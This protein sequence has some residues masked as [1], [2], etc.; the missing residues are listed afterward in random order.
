MTPLLSVYYEDRRRIARNI[1]SH[2]SLGNSSRL[3]R[4][5][6]F[7]FVL[8]MLP[9]GGCASDHS[10]EHRS[11]ERHPSDRPFFDSPDPESLH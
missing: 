1:F 5:T 3:V 11:A 4:A 7:F 2:I 6:I 8:S 9:L 10:L